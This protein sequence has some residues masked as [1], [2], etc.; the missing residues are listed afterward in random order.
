MRILCLPLLL[1]VA[2]CS[3]APDAAPS[4]ASVPVEW[5]SVATSNDRERIRSWREAWTRA[6]AAARAAGHG[7]AVAREGALLH[8]DAAL[9][10][11][12]PPP[13]AYRCRVTKLGARSSG[14]LDFVAYPHFACRVR[15]ES[16]I[17]SLAKL[18]GS[19]RPV[20]LIFPDTGRRGIF[21]GTLELG[22]ERRA[23]Q[24][25]QDRERDLAALVERIGPARWRLV[26]PYPHFESLVDVVELIPQPEFRS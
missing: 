4:T 7:Q 13:G 8:P 21:L 12:P 14:L 9:A 11:S 18:T 3:S 22:D 1:T 10:Y 16:G 23:L 15:L 6:L 24:Y 17:L 25:G 19:Q 2:A 20:G 26:F 5:R